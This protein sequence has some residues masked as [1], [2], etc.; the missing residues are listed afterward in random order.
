MG[1]LFN[2]GMKFYLIIQKMVSFFQLNGTKNTDDYTVI[3]KSG[4][5]LLFPR[6]LKLY[7]HI[8]K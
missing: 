2:L 7:V 4:I 8:F 5:V 6:F 1:P 3:N